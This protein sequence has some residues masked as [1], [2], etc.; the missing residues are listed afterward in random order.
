MKTKALF[1]YSFILTFALLLHF[2]Y[3][4]GRNEGE[5]ISIMRVEKVMNEAAQKNNLALTFDMLEN[6]F[7]K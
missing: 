5:E 2:A 7:F 3:R 6:E 4:M 1:V